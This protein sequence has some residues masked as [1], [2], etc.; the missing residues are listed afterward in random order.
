MIMKGRSNHNNPVLQ[1]G[2]HTDK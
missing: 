2:M 1:G